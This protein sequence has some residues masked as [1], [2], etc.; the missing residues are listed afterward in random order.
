MKSCSVAGCTD[1]YYGKGL[2]GKHYKRLRITGTLEDGPKAHAPL[3]VRFWRKVAK[4]GP[5]DCWLWTG[6]LRAG[7]YGHIQEGGKGSRSLLTHRVSWEIA[8]GRPAPADMV[9]MHRCDNPTCVNPAHLEL[10]T[11]AENTADMMTKGRKKVAAPVGNENGKA[12]LTPEMV[13]YIR[14]SDKTHAALARELNVSNNAVRGVRIG[15]T[16]SHVT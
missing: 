5:D 7:G 6:G 8:N 13:R 16:W 3:E 2:C 4:A 1:T 15:R 11:H 9:V 12:L 10:G 14:S